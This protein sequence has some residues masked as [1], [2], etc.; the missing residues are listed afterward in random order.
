MGCGIYKILNIK[1]NKVYVGSSINLSNRE[2]KHFWMLTNNSHDNLYL[3][4]SFNKFGKDFF[5]FEVLEYCEPKNLIERE[6]FFISFYQSDKNNKGYNLATVNEFRRNTYNN[7]V[8]IRLSKYGLN[9]NANFIKFKLTSML[10]NNTY[11]FDNLVDAANYL[12]EFGYS[13]GNPKHIRMKL[14]SSL[15]NKKVNNGS[16]G[17]IRKTCY[18]HKFEIIN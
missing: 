4:N 8:K 10:T 7:D 18:K 6:N 13:K 11:V 12:I 14:S 2:Y 15:R 3:Q 17:S 5:K 1:N 9:N 16:N